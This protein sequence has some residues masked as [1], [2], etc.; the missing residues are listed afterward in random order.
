[1]HSIKRHINDILKVANREIGRLAGGRMYWFCMIIAPLLS[2]AFFLSLMHD[3][4]PTKLPVALV[5]LDNSSTS[6]SLARQMN[7]FTEIDIVMHAK[8]FN[9][10]RVEMQKGNIYAIYLI[11]ENFASDAA[12]GKQSTLSFY[13]NNSYLI[14]SSLLFKDM[15]TVS[16]LSSGAVALQTGRAK[17]YTDSQIMAQVQPIVIDTHPIGN[18]WLNYSVY[19]NNVILPG[20]LAL[21]IMC[22]TVYSIGIEIKEHT[23]L[24]WLKSGDGS[25]LK[26]L[27]GKMLPQTIVF[28]IVGLI[29]FFLIYIVL[30]FPMNSSIWAMILALFM[31][32]I[33]SQALGIFMIGVL[34]TLR[35]GLS[36][37]CIWGMIAFSASGFSFPVRAMYAPLQALTNLFPLKH[38]FDIY[39]DQALN[40]MEL[41]YSWPSYLALA[42]F[43]ILPFFTMSGLKHSLL[44][45]TYQP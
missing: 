19:L 14:A 39:S 16:T 37:A 32:I 8:D 4:L 24:E 43:L 11:P 44:Y 36:F 20:I 1:M 23:K 25:I 27:F 6:R 22:V 18:P 15:K 7:S 17:G 34:P 31:L 42:G 30:Q 41:F 45:S 10:A 33:A 9:E 29:I 40:G 3:G 13:T 35:L 12:T 2:A 26:S 21:L 5:D 38:Y 28:F